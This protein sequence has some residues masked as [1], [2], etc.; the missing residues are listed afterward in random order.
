VIV[1]ASTIMVGLV[2]LGSTSG[3]S[4]VIRQIRIGLRDR[5]DRNLLRHIYDQDRQA[6]VL[7]TLGCLRRAEPP[8]TKPASDDEETAGDKAEPPDQ[9]RHCS[10]R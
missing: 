6:D 7:N 1:D 10:T 8:L 2:A 4:L 5:G 3:V 9:I